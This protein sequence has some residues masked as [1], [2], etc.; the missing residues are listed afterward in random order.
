MILDETKVL[1]IVKQIPHEHYRMLGGEVYIFRL[2]D[3]T[4]ALF[5]EPLSADELKRL[6]RM[7]TAELRQLG[8]RI[9]RQH[10]HRRVIFFHKCA[11]TAKRR[12]TRMRYNTR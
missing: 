10:D 8:C 9:T 1:E 11:R 4:R 7:I 12:K 3:F 2:S 5:K 6:S